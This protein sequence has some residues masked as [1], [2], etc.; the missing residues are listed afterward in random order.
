MAFQIIK[1]NLND[2]WRHSWSD[3]TSIDYFLS[4]GFFRTTGTEFSLYSESGGEQRA[5]ELADIEVID[6]TDAGIPETF[7]TVLALVTRL[8]A[9]NYPYF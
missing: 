5:A 3:N 1:E 4:D 8:K 2:V 6:E 7:V 9:L